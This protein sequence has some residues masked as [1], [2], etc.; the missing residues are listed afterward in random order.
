MRKAAANRSTSPISG[1]TIVRI[2][3]ASYFMALAIGLIPGTD[4]A[5]L[6]S[7]LMPWIAARIV[8]GAL[9]FTLA[10][11]ILVG[12]QRRAAALL[13][14][15]VIFWASYMTLLALPGA[16]DIGSFWR[17]LALIGALILTYADAEDLGHNDAVAVFRH[18]PRHNI[19]L[20]RRPTSQPRPPALDIAERRFL[21]ALAVSMVRRKANRTTQVEL[22]Q[23]DA[24]LF[25]EDF[26]LVRAS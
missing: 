13:L 11:M 22:S 26:D 23:K 6:I 7:W 9:V 20:A 24:N 25:R 8:T 16:E 19:K 3:I 12:V 18:L 21:P 14:A 1:H 5:I 4:P 10:L 2:L 15:I 17:D